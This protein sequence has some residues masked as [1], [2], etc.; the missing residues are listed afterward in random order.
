MC[1]ICIFSLTV[2]GHV[3]SIYVY[4]YVFKGGKTS[5]S[6]KASKVLRAE[7]RASLRAAGQGWGQE[8]VPLQ[9]AYG[10]TLRLQLLI[11]RPAQSG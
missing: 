11:R 9:D 2:W 7:W 6:N 4:I 3:Y 1:Y 5:V 10:A 8:Q